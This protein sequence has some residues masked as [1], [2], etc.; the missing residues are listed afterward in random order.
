[1]QA[2]KRILSLTLA[3]VLVLALAACG[4]QSSTATTA[5]PETTEAATEAAAE[6]ATEA[7]AEV[8]HTVYPLTI[9]TYNYAKEPVEYTFEKA[10]ERV[11]AQNQDNIEILLA[12]GL[13]D[14]SVGACGLDGEVREDLQADF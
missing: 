14:K 5:A 4:A 3:L 8:K 12:L 1:M 7:P 13:A 10:P 11:W 2:A 9:Q 6:A